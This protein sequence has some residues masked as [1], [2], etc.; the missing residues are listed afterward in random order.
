MSN[1]MQFELKAFILRDFLKN[2]G[3]ELSQKEALEVIAMMLKAELDDCKQRLHEL[4]E[5]LNV[6]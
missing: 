6:E 1:E 4:K 3:F 2:G 5:I